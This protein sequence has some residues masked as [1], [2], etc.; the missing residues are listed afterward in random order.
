[1]R[2]VSA[3]AVGDD[4]GVVSRG[5]PRR[6]H[7]ADLGVA[8]LH[9][10]AVGKRLVGDVHSSAGRKVRGCAGA[11]DELGQSRYVVGL[12]VCLEYGDDRHALRLRQGDVVLNEGSV[13]VDDRQPAVRLA[14]EQVGRARRFVVEQLSEVHACLL[15]FEPGDLTSYQLIA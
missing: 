6:R 12:Q 5:V 9:D 10:L 3:G 15:S 13:G 2:L 7:R 8:E 4:V 11:L 14:P 1:M